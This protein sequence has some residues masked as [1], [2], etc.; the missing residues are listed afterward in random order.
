MTHY[1]YRTTCLVNGKTYVGVRSCE[2][3]PR[4]DSYLGSG[5]YLLHAIRKYGREAFSK[6]VL[7]IVGTREEALRIEAALVTPA[8]CRDRRNYNRSPGGGSPPVDLVRTPEQRE[9]YRQAMTPERK[10]RLREINLGNQR[11]LGTTGSERH[12]RAV[13][14]ANRR[15]AR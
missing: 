6:Q 15:R 9:R 4:E 13:A 14:E 3:D 7:V 10:A 5:T 12:R 11:R 2:G 8:V 1:V